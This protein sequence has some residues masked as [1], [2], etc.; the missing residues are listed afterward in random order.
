MEI[1]THN[2]YRS[3]D[4]IQNAGARHGGGATARA[5]YIYDLCMLSLFL[6]MGWSGV[7]YATPKI[8]AALPRPGVALLVAGGLAYTAG[9]PFF[10]WGNKRLLWH[11]LW[12]VFVL[13]GHAPRPGGIPPLAPLQQPGVGSPRSASPAQRRGFRSGFHFACVYFFVYSFRPADH[14]AAAGLAAAP[15]VGRLPVPASR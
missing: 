12:H 10:R 11:A 3:K 13:A 8:L 4:S 7:F 15:A 9:V 2:Y 5:A 1:T 14:L 6:G